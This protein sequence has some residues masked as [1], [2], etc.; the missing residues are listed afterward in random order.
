VAGERS[1]HGSHLL[2]SPRACRGGSLHPAR[3]STCRLAATGAIAQ[4]QCPFWVISG[5][6]IVD[7]RCPLQ[8][9][10]KGLG[11]SKGT[12]TH[13]CFTLLFPTQIGC[14]RAFVIQAP[15]RS[16]RGRFHVAAGS[17]TSKTSRWD[18]GLY[19]TWAAAR[20][21]PCGSSDTGRQGTPSASSGGE[22]SEKVPHLRTAKT[23]KTPSLFV[24]G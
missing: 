3:R 11:S 24:S 12:L 23:V 20:T 1:G 22:N 5:R 10:W 21:R 2:Q 16:R 13:R 17:R 4:K 9:R 15:R 18:G 14:S 8:P 6:K 7:Q 19:G